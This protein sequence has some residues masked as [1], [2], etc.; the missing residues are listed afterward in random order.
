MGA[1]YS[2]P[3][4][5]QPQAPPHFPTKGLEFVKPKPELSPVSPK[6]TT[7]KS[8]PIYMPSQKLL[9]SLDT[10]PENKAQMMT[11]AISTSWTNALSDEELSSRFSH[12][13]TAEALNPWWKQ[14]AAACECHAC[15]AKFST[16]RRKHHCRRCGEIFCY[17]CTKQRMSLPHLNYGRTP[18][19]VCDRCHT[20]RSKQLQ[21]LKTGIMVKYYAQ[22]THGL[23]SKIMH[24]KLSFQDE[25]Q[26]R[27]SW[28]SL[29]RVVETTSIDFHTINGIISGP[30]NSSF[31]SHALPSTEDV[32]EDLFFTLKLEDGTELYFETITPLQKKE[33]WIAALQEC[34]LQYQ[35]KETRIRQ[36]A[37]LQNKLNA[38]DEDSDDEEDVDSEVETEEDQ[39]QDEDLSNMGGLPCLAVTFPDELMGPNGS[40]VSTRRD[41]LNRRRPSF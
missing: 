37:Q 25:D 23:R 35:N 16:F 29:D 32:I 31:A 14:D 22:E 21:T 36:V 34:V 30:S 38:S 8:A 40:A 28:R 3:R 11:A 33:E 41:I 19:R 20:F 27:L 12:L 18:V 13:V 7:N 26:L 15:K 24:M 39:D 10:L 17:A 2:S 1:V 5:A 9:Q 4:R 6:T